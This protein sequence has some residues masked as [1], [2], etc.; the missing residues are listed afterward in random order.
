M[1]ILQLEECSVQFSLVERLLSQLPPRFIS[2]PIWTPL[3]A[4]PLTP[5]T[6]KLCENHFIDLKVDKLDPS[7]DGE[8]G[9]EPH[10]DAN[11]AD[12]SR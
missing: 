10:G 8:A 11:E 1:V 3:S 7:E 6:S 12:L 5:L 4:T 2:E 9:E